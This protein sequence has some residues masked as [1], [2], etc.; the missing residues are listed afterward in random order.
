MSYAH[1]TSEIPVRP[2]DIDMNQHVHSS[3]YMDYVLAARHD[4][5]DRC[6]GMS[7]DEFI[8]LGYGWVIAEGHLN[9][10][11]PLFLG[12]VALITTNIHEI[13]EME[14]TVHFSIKRKKDNKLSCDGWFRY[15][16]VDATTGRAVKVPK[17]IVEKYSI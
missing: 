3:R 12:D 7:M 16:M 14:C 9:F 11:R 10:K 17:E 15:T 8:K 5:M 1:F 6:Y 13:K 2:D 4:Q